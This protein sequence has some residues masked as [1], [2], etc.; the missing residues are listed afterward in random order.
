MVQMKRPE[1]VKLIL[2]MISAEESLFTQVEERITQRWGKIDFRSPILLFQ[3]TDYYEKEMGANLKRKFLSFESLIDPGEIIQV[4]LFTNRLE[5][6]FLYP[7]L[8]RRRL[9][10]DPGYISLSKLV[11]TSTKNFEHRIYLGRGIYAEITLKYKRGRGFQP[12]EVTYPDYR[13][14]EYLDIF[15]HLR[16]IYHQQL[17]REKNED[18]H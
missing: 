2:G 3:G 4:K 9:N 13:R 1:P 16:Q 6:E 18:L 5:Q 10:L 11:L 14:T 7:H 15:N 8:S 17:G 12:G